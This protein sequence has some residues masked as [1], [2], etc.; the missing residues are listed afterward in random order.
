MGRLT[1]EMTRLC[2]EIV[3]RRGARKGFVKD[4]TQHVA[5]LKAD[6]HRSHADMARKS[7]TERRAFMSH[8]KTTVAGL[9]HEFAA[10]LQG[11]R[12]AWVGK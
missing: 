8:L 4:L 9:R 7:K 3:D 6:F 11:A 12:R 10:D 1:D 2:H 5:A